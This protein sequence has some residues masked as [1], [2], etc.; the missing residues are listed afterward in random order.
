MFNISGIEFFN[1]LILVFVNFLV[2]VIYIN[3][4]KKKKIWFLPFTV[5]NITYLFNYPLK[6]F[7]LTSGIIDKSLIEVVMPYTFDDLF[8][9]LL[10]S[11]AYYVVFNFLIL[12]VFY[13]FVPRFNTQYIFTSFKKYKYKLINFSLFMFVTMIFI[14]YIKFSTLKYYGFG[15]NKYYG[16]FDLLVTNIELLKYL[17]VLLLLTIYRLYQKKKFL[18]AALLISMFIILD[19]V[20]STSKTP[21]F[22]LFILYLVYTSLFEIKFNKVL[23]SIMVFLGIVNFYYSYVVR[24]Y[25]NIR[26]TVTSDTIINNFYIVYDKF[27]DISERVLSAFVNR[28]ELLDNLI[29]TM[30]RVD[31]I[32]KGYFQ[33][34]S[35]SEVLNII[36]RSIW[37]DK[38]NLQLSYYIIDVVQGKQMKGV[39][40]GFG[41]IGE[42][43]FVLGHYGILYALINA[44]IM[45][46][47]YN[48]T[49]FS[50]KKHSLPLIIY[51]HLY[52][53][54]FA[55]DNY[56]FQGFAGIVLSTAFIVGLL[57]IIPNKRINLK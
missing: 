3:R 37:P 24:Y 6:A 17:T 1:I 26:G 41:R 28:F 16:V 22:M 42:S 47:I 2:F 8:E 14:Y 31:F 30:K 53:I 33:L 44:L 36:P 34:G 4:M 54:Y 15:G 5:F 50:M 9:A 38:P 20:I 13:P 56:I 11:T 29:I 57:F 23:V 18:F 51:F 21:I 46:V 27:G 32:D 25:G 19:S 48:K 10:Y 55:Q 40:A 35:I 52:F 45:V 49:V 12:F 39:S 7:V 43:F